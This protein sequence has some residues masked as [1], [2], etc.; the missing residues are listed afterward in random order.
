MGQ[1][2]AQDS[3][4]ATRRQGTFW[5]TRAFSALFHENSPFSHI[6]KPPTRDDSHVVHPSRRDASGLSFLLPG[7][8]SEALGGGKS[9]SG[10]PAAV[11]GGNLGIVSA[12]AT[13]KSD[14]R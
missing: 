12:W 11:H 6:G 5:Q 2:N 14:L 10:A 9:V 13:T 8:R 4:R 7:L 3:A 1:R